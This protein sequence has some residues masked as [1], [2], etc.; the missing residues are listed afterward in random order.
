M[1]KTNG[2]IQVKKALCLILAVWLCT[3]LLAGCAGT[4]EEPAPGASSSAET[5]ESVPSSSKTQETS[6]TPA[7]SGTPDETPGAQTE[8]TGPASETPAPADDQP[9]D[10][11][12]FLGALVEAHPG[13]NAEKL[14]EAMLESPYF[15][16]FGKQSVE[17][18]WPFFKFGFKPTG[19]GSAY[20]ISESSGEATVIAVVPKSDA[21]IE[22]LIGQLNDNLERPTNESAPDKLLLKEI[23]GTIFVALYYGD[24][25]PITVYAE[26]GRDYVAMF[27][28]YLADHPGAGCLEMAEFFA[29][30]QKLG[31]MGV[32]PAEEGKLRGFGVWDESIGWYLPVEISGF[33]DGARFEPMMEPNA[34]MGYI[35]RLKEG[36]NAE[37]FVKTLRDNANLAY[38]VCTSVDTVITETDGDYVLFMMCNE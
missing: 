18:Y 25:R 15:S 22:A 23:G 24:M 8:P 35:F 32:D 5:S 14:C 37:A 19:V 36:V 7:E 4:T 26:K 27:H 9:I 28:D 2:G 1:L 3:A 10:M 33:A 13:A 16:L 20:C 38:N 6:G 17:F 34:F 31:R 11:E 12:A 30:R 21:D 29:K